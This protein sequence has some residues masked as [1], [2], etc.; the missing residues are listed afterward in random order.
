MKILYIDDSK[1]DR[2]LVKESLKKLEKAKIVEAS[3]KEE[4]D[5]F[6]K[7]DLFDLVIT[8]FNISG[9]E[10]I[11]IIEE[12]KRISPETAIIVLTGTGSEEIAVESLKKGADD[13]VIKTVNHIKKLPEIIKTVIRKKKLEK[14]AKE[15][16][17]YL[18]SLGNS[19]PEVIFDIKLPER[20][21][22]YVNMAVE[23]VFG[24]S[25]EELIGKS[26][27]ILFANK[28]DFKRLGK[29][30][31]TAIKEGK[32]KITLE[33]VLKKKKGEIFYAEITSTP[34][35][36]GGN[37]LKVIDIV[38]D[39]SERKEWEIKIKEEQIK[40]KSVFESSLD[41][42]FLM[43]RDRF[44]DCNS[45]AAQLF[46]CEKKDIVGKPP[47]LFSP[48]TQPTGEN[49][50][51]LAKEK[52]N[53]A[54]AGK[55]QRFEWVHKTF[56]GNLINC[57]VS[58]NKFNLNKKEYITA[59]VRDITEK[60][61]MENEI[62]RQNEMLKHIVNL[63]PAIV[64]KLNPETFELEWF[65]ENLQKLLG[66]SKEDIAKKDWWKKNIYPE[67]LKKKEI[68]LKRIFKDKKITRE[69]RF[70]K[71][72]GE[73]VWIR[74]ELVLIENKSKQ[75]ELIGA[76]T[77]ITELK[78]KQEES[79]RRKK[80][81][82]AIASNSKDAIVLLNE[83][84]QIIFWNKAAEKIFG[85]REKEVLF[86]NPHTFLISPIKKNAE[87]NNF[88][89][90]KVEKMFGKI[91]HKT[92]ITKK[93]KKIDIEVSLSKF[94]LG[95]D[96]YFLAVMRDIT[97][98]LK[99]HHEI[100][101]ERKKFE[102]T[103]KS[104]TDAVVTLDKKGKITYMNPSAEQL[105]GI[106][107]A[108]ALRKKLTSILKIYPL[109]ERERIKSLLNELSEKSKR[110]TTVVD[111]FLK[112]QNKK[113]E[114]SMTISPITFKTENEGLVIVI[115]NLTQKQ[116]L[117]KEI[118]K[119]ERLEAINRIAGGIA[120]DF[121]NLLNALY[122]NIEL[123]LRVKD[124]DKMIEYLKKSINSAERAKFLATQLL[125]LSKEHKVQMETDEIGLFLRE[126]VEFSLSGTSIQP[127]FKIPKNLW[128]VKYD[129]NLLGQVIQNII[130]N[131]VQ[132]MENKGS[133]IEV[134]ATNLKLKDK[135]VGVLSS[136]N[137][138]KITIKDYGK[139]IPPEILPKI[140]EPFFTTKKEGS[141]LGLA[142]SFSIIRKHNGWIEAESEVGKGTQI[143]IYLPAVPGKTK[144]K[145]KKKA[146]IV[147]RGSGNILVMDDEKAIR[148]IYRDT[149]T[150][151]GYKVI[152][153]SNGEEAVEFFKNKVLTGETK[154][155]AMF[156]DLTVTG[157]MGGQ[158]AC[159]EIRK[160]D[161]TIPIFVASGYSKD[162][163]I[164]NPEKYGFTASLPKPFSIRDMEN[165]LAKFF[166]GK[167]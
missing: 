115:R 82:E 72:N 130:L 166:D 144:K 107:F 3:K 117:Y 12:I 150:L 38:R 113:I 104:I 30:T 5:F 68:K 116:R 1:S 136:G 162:P 29:Q 91:I 43:D 133:K 147:H 35:I 60:K 148:E 109:K 46:E 22:T 7:N 20:I 167:D 141:G 124:R 6:L 90:K 73:L 28:R 158:E 17:E 37:I 15:K 34:V 54:Y 83:K 121:N 52:I 101:E 98:R 157:G 59:I 108:Q 127:E 118:A 155:K 154:L 65:S 47:Y 120:H 78:K 55:P 93:G 81:L 26:T 100:E 103:I 125:T 39:I 152:E 106:K 41:A 149:L 48:E 88:D 131:S 153:T 10:G 140:F 105:L 138:V 163:I 95:D 164:Q 49:S 2:A 161:K 31:L 126:I 62:K 71:K 40:F 64:Y 53:L 146:T 67:D 66:Y 36:R 79:E 159:E 63:S 89:I 80:L 84:G 42:I 16:E 145:K 32:T 142:T 44:I 33:A 45:A 165:L 97:D 134:S 61:K 156:F 110:E 9:V 160:Y 25:P 132:A 8:D 75:I 13:Y 27:E 69:Y 19:L 23:K 58:L 122:G 18:N 56:K 112:H 76:W 128:A 21:I 4:F 96:T 51:K 50:K 70:Y 57:E 119:V 24:Y 143:H 114:I 123:A 102:L 85:Y 86:K 87:K 111:T 11:E 135:Q 129:R 94:E 77:D 137:Y 139:G 14:E 92:A 74:D 151:L 99:M